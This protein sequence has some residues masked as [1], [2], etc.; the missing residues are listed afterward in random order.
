MRPKTP[1]YI[2]LDFSV[3][4]NDNESEIVT[5]FLVIKIWNQNHKDWDI[6]YDDAFVTC[7]HNQDTVGKTTI[8]R[9]HQKR[10]KTT[11]FLQLQL[12]VD[13]RKW[14]SL[15]KCTADKS[16]A[17]LQVDVATRIKYRLLGIKIKHHSLKLSCRFSVGSDGNI[18]G[19]KKVR[20]QRRPAKWKIRRSLDEIWI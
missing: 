18:S 12:I 2:L 13:R 5:M 1:V 19:K 20:L 17:K 4:F 8:P 7:Y 11:T 14:S 3:H 16:T 6:Y 9:L 10:H 15:I